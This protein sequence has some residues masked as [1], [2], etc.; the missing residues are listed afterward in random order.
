MSSPFAGSHTTLFDY[1]GGTENLVIPE[2]Q[3]E[4]SWGRNTS[5]S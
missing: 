1:F 3:R 4:F 5:S 2:Y